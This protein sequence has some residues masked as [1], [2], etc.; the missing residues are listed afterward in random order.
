MDQITPLNKMFDNAQSRQRMDQIWQQATRQSAQKAS[1]S[2]SGKETQR[3]GAKAQTGKTA[4]QQGSQKGAR[5]DAN[6]PVPTYSDVEKSQ[7]KKEPGPLYS[8]HS[9]AS[10][11]G[12]QIATR[13][14][15]SKP[16]AIFAYQAV[17]SLPSA[18]CTV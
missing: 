16:W 17:T 18:R 4:Q 14:S 3:A 13:I 6:L 1:E 10:A 5:T 7:K 9:S 15:Y 12:S 11:S 2:G 8:R